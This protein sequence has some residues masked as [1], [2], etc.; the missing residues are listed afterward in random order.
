[1]KER[2]TLTLDSELLKQVDDSVNGNT[3]KNRSHA[4]ELS[5]IKALGQNKP[6]KAIIL[7]GGSK[8]SGSGP[9][10]MKELN[11][12]PIIQH[13][14]ELLKRYGICEVIISIGPLGDAIKN[15]FGSGKKLGLNISYIEENEPL[16]TAGPLFSLRDSLK[17]SF[18]VCNA[19]ELKDIDL[20]DLFSF[21]NE[22]GAVATVALTTVSDPKKYGSVKMK[23]SNIIEFVEK[24]KKEITS[25]LISCGTYVLSPEIFQYINKGKSMLETNVFPKLAREGKLAGYVTEGTWIDTSTDFEKAQKEWKG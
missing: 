3:I 20:M 8:K 13:S 14:L 5:L 12:K 17:N 15:Y 24:P 21:H 25:R 19:D 23:G 22:N 4:I 11:E 1:M 16:G 18:L 6:L 2:V 9:F 7:A 10:C